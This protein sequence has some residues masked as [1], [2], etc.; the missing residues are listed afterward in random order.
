[1]RYD[2]S[3]GITLCKKCHDTTKGNEEVY[4]SFFY[5]LL[6][7]QAIQRLKKKKEDDE[8]K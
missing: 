7:H 2:V 6:E 4:E 3:N 1:M 5:K 8:R